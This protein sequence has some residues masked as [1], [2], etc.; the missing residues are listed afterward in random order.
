MERQPD[1]DRNSLVGQ[2]RFLV[3]RARVLEDQLLKHMQP[4]AYRRI[5]RYM[6][7]RGRG[8]QAVLSAMQAAIER[9]VDAEMPGHFDP[10]GRAGPVFFVESRAKN[11]YSIYRKMQR[12][13]KSLRHI[14]DMLGIR[15][16]C[17][18]VG[19]CYR[20]LGLVHRMWHPVSGRFKD[21]I[22]NP[23]PNGYRGLHTTVETS[24]GDVVE[25]QIRTFGMHVMAELGSADHA[26]Y[27]NTEVVH[28]PGEIRVRY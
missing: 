3:H 17:G 5:K 22:V 7:R 23:K 24:D 14:Y 10:T 12:S 16:I 27:K 19:D 11:V 13:G 28:V 21:Y 4:E 25:I 18:D 9:Q 8:R 2:Q 26:T 15:L 6:D 20:L 1:G